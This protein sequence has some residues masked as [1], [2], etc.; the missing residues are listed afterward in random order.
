[1]SDYVLMLYTL[2]ALH[3]SAAFYSLTLCTEQPEAKHQRLVLSLHFIMLEIQYFCYIM[4]HCGVVSS[5]CS[6]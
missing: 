2:K 6:C 1:M 3:I 5:I 4:I